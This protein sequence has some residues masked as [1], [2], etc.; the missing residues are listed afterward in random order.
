M[1]PFAGGI[2]FAA[3]KFIFPA[4]WVSLQ[5]VNL[6]QHHKISHFSRWIFFIAKCCLLLA[7]YFFHKK[8]IYPF[9]LSRFL[10]YSFPFSNLLFQSYLPALKHLFSKSRISG[11]HLAI[12]TLSSRPLPSPWILVA[13]VAS[14]LSSSRTLVVSIP[15]TRVIF[16]H[17]S[18]L[19]F[20]N[21]E[22]EQLPHTYKKLFI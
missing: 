17:A 15:N 20:I 12:A 18:D 22:L 9:S 6:F 21:R 16:Y 5:N 2:I 7:T 13:L 14:P 1:F 19:K 8:N 4:T 3:N 11:R 10:L